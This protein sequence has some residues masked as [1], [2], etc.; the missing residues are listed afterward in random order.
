MC[1][2]LS[3]Y[4]CNNDAFR[5]TL[6]GVEPQNMLMYQPLEQAAMTAPIAVDRVA[7]HACIERVSRDQAEPATAILFRPVSISE[8][9]QSKR[10]LEKEHGSRDLFSIAGARTVFA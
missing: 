6:G 7:L 4:D 10:R 5:I 1:L 2:E 9:Q 8:R 3:K